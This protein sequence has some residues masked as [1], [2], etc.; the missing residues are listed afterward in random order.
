MEIID[1]TVAFGALSQETRLKIFRLLIQTGPTGMPA[2]EI[3]EKLNVLPN[4]LSSN[5]NNLVAAGLI[6]KERE[7]RS[8]RYFADISGLQ[9]LLGYLLQDC[10]GGQ[11]ELCQPLINDL[12]ANTESACAPATETAHD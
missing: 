6:R 1:A 2:G 11:A 8:I 4:T 10:C 12:L 7:G 9:N 3:G 5:L